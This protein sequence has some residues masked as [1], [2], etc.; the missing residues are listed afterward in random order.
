MAVRKVKAKAKIKVKA[1]AIAKSKVKAATKVVPKILTFDQMCGASL[2]SFDIK[3]GSTSV[4]ELPDK[5]PNELTFNHTKVGALKFT[6][7]AGD[8]H[9]VTVSPFS[10][11]YV[12]T[13]TAVVDQAGDIVNWTFQVLDGA[14][15]HLAVGQTLTQLYTLTL[16]D[17]AGNV[18]T[19]VVTVTIVGTND[20][21][22]ITSNLQTGTATEIADGAPGENTDT[23]TQNGNITFSDVDL[24]DTHNAAVAPL[25]N[26]YLGTL[27]LGGVD[28]AGNSVPWT[29]TVSDQDL[30]PLKPGEIRT[31]QYQVTIDDNHGGTATTIITI[32]LIGARRRGDRQRPR[33]RRR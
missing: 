30:D 19:A 29:F 28:Q 18:T 9:T 25:G 33:H 2:P 15:D 8:T 23:H 6:D 31:Q 7:A 4:V 12:G 13:L 17:F 32:T 24:I 11:G 14:I 16:K 1:K 5:D 10:G 3:N 27:V 20:A 26:G 22:E 21:P